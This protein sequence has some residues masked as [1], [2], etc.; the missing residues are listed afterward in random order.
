PACGNGRR[1]VAG[2][3][4][5]SAAHMPDTSTTVAPAAGTASAP[6]SPAI[7]SAPAGGGPT[8]FPGA[9]PGKT[10]CPYKGL[11]PYDETYRDYFI[12]RDR[13]QK[14]IIANLHAAPLTVFYGASGV[15]KS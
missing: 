2:R 13:E 6:S 1:A 14:I 5:E 8:A 3:A 7:P 15:G 9:G 4:T 10:F 12:G 11:E